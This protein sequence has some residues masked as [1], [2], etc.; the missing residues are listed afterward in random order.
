MKADNWLSLHVQAWTKVKQMLEKR[1]PKIEEDDL[2]DA[3]ELKET[4][5]YCVLYLAYN[6]P[7]L[8]ESGEK[9]RKY[10]WKRYRKSF[11]EVELTISGV[12]WPAEA[13]SNMRS[14]RG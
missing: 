1:L 8:S 13:Y 10:W 5:V 14:L 7:E 9:R 12:A 6:S 2:D 11:A 4:T 3:D